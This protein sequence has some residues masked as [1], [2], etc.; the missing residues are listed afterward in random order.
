[1]TFRRK[2]DKTEPPPRMELDLVNAL[3]ASD[4]F[5]TSLL[6]TGLSAR[7]SMLRE[8]DD[9]KSK[10]GKASDDSVLFP[11]RQSRLNDFG[12]TPQ[13][14]S[15]IAEVGSIRESTRRP[16]ALDRMDSF[17]SSA[18]SSETDAQ[19][20]IM[21]RGK[22]AEGNNLFGGRQ[23]IY[24][25]PMGGSASMKSL[26]GTG[27]SSGLGGRAL[28]GDDVSQSAFQ[29]LKERE[30]E[31]R[32]R[33]NER[34]SQEEAYRSESPPAGYNRN[35]ETSSTTSSGPNGTRISTAA[36]SVTSQ[37]TPSVTGQSSAPTTPA[38]PGPERS[39]TKTKRLYET[40]LD[41]HLHTQQFSAANRLDN[42]SRQG[43]NLGA[44]SPSPAGSPIPSPLEQGQS[45]NTGRQ[46][47]VP[48]SNPTSPI[49]GFDFG[50][51][52]PTPKDALKP[53]VTTPPLSSPVSETDDKSA[54]PIQ[55]NDKG[56]ATAL[57]AFAKPV[58]PYDERKYTQ[59]Q[60]QMQQGRETPPLRKHAPPP[61]FLPNAA[62][63]D[64]APRNR[65]GSN[66]TYQS[67]LSRESST[68]REFT[69]RERMFPPKREPPPEP[70]QQQQVGAGMGS[71]LTS[72]GDSS[73]ASS[74]R[75]S[76]EAGR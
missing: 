57:G 63:Q 30:R 48:L 66:A 3:P 6:M 67:D 68:Q 76:A 26:N 2:K 71:F 45:S 60:L 64:A 62:S 23:K 8:Q 69:P 51:T 54:L 39:F 32:E 46:P 59:R 16:F 41:Q 36:T 14:L 11:N 21:S 58:Q 27:E 18:G 75:G 1:M 74:P 49:G 72:P 20:S 56:K 52:K 73:A 9:P 37:R 42:L 50:T 13:G 17:Q 70:L 5:R 4:D 61:S 53:L 47:R 34:R 22:P 65:A 38:V 24:K 44:R 33:E 15:D 43:R 10:I 12:F 7:F 28:Y 29:K 19:E 25:I 35:R 40:G 55:P 31:E